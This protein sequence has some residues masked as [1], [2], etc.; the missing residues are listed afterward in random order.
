MGEKCCEVIRGDDRWR[1][2]RCS[3]NATV[4]RGGKHYCTKHDPER[5]KALAKARN[6]RHDARHEANLAA[7]R[8]RTA[9]LAMFD[10][11]VDA[12]CVLLDALRRCYR[13]DVCMGSNPMIGGVSKVEFERLVIPAIAKAD[14]VVSR[15]RKLQES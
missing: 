15:A 6:D 13:T 9:K 5:R 4:E 1:R 2:I 10:E 8:T 7:E 11:L 14:D 12:K 3:R